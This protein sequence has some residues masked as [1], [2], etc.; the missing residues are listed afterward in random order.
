MSDADGK[1]DQKPGFGSLVPRR[2]DTL[3]G[4]SRSYSSRRDVDFSSTE[5]ADIAETQYARF[6]GVRNSRHSQ[7]QK[8]RKHFHIASRGADTP[9]L[10]AHMAN[11][12]IFIWH[13]PLERNGA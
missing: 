6:R 1:T 2:D 9:S 4:Q 7:K 3:T 13:Q 10:Y 8:T 11:C 12:P 5:R